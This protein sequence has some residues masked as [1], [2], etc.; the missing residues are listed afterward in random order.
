M[1]ENYILCIMDT[2]TTSETAGNCGKSIQ[3]KKDL[4][5]RMQENGRL[6]NQL[7]WQTKY[8]EE[9]IKSACIIF[10]LHT[11]NAKGL[12]YKFVIQFIISTISIGVPLL[13]Q[14][15]TIIL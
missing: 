7:L 1:T 14:V 3:D 4:K 12:V 2:L 5:L 9:S 10:I 8:T 11:M 6:S 15:R 13:S